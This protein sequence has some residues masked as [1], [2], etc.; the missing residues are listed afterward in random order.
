LIE[1]ALPELDEAFTLTIP[2]ELV[3]FTFFIAMNF[4]S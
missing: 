2:F 3:D 1:G 4:M